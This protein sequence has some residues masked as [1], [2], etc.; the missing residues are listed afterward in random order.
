[1]SAHVQLYF[2]WRNSAGCLLDYSS[3]SFSA[4]HAESSSHVTHALRDFLFG[5]CLGEGDT[6][7]I[8][9]ARPLDAL[10]ADHR[11]TPVPPANEAPQ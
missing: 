6:I 1:M 3:K 5:H 11:R 10:V 8:T 9:T 7:E 4:P 2:V